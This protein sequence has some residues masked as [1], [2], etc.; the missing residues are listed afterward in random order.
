MHI[1][2]FIMK[3]NKLT[4]RM[5]V[6][7]RGK[8]KATLTIAKEAST[9]TLKQAV[10]G[11]ENFLHIDSI[12]VWLRNRMWFPTTFGCCDKCGKGISVKP[13]KA[14]YLSKDGGALFGACPPRRGLLLWLD[15]ALSNL[16]KHL[17][18][19]LTKIWLLKGSFNI[20]KCQKAKH[21]HT[22]S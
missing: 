20:S 15:F 22:S 8:T 6:S 17:S 14:W 16:C 21:P 5:W 7:I 1:Y 10:G 18:S 9:C 2:R 13:H 4:W 12:S 19:C 3:L 11:L